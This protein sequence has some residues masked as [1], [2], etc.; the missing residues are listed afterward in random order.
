[1][2]QRDFLF[3]SLYRRDFVPQN[4]PSLD[5]LKKEYIQY[6]LK[7]TGNDVQETA[8]I[9]GISPDSLEDNLQELS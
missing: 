2:E 6:L 9:L 1:M 4:C 5:R 3:Y 8:D 7:L